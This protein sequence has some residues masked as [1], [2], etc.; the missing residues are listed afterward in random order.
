MN[1]RELYQWLLSEGCEIRPKEGINNSAPPIE[2]VNKKTGRFSY[3]ASPA[4]RDEVSKNTVQKLIRDLG[5][6]PP[7]NF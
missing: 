7:Q 3:F 6:Q 5:L 2:V 4:S 1:K